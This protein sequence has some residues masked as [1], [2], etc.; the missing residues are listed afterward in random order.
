MR[1]RVLLVGGD[2]RPGPGYPPAADA[3]PH[4]PDSSSG[5]QGKKGSPLAGHGRRPPRCWPVALRRVRAWLEP[6]WFRWRCWRAGSDQPPPDA[7]QTLLDWLH[8]G[9]PLRLYDAS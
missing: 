8:H 6:A 9:H 3:D 7:L 2:P 5:E 4:D 1:V